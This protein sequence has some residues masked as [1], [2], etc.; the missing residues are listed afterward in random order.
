MCRPP[1]YALVLPHE[2]RGVGE[3]RILMVNVGVGVVANHVLMIPH[4]RGRKPG[5]KVRKGCVN[6]PVAAHTEVKSVVPVVGNDDPRELRGDDKRPPL[7]RNEIRYCREECGHETENHGPSLRGGLGGLPQRDSSRLGNGLEVFHDHFL[8]VE[9]E[10]VL[11][12]LVPDVVR[13]IIPRVNSLQILCLFRIDFELVE[14][15]VESLVRHEVVMR[16]K[17]SRAVTSLCEIQSYGT[18]RVVEFGEIVPLT[19]DPRV[20]VSV[21]LL[22]VLCLVKDISSVA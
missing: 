20:K 11:L 12:V 19:P 4:P 8:N 3:V 7:T 9:R 1:P 10:R 18:S 14:H 6:A 22:V 15:A 13:A 17:E 16:L 21:T 2:L 5:E